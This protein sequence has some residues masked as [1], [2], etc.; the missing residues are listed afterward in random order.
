MAAR[1]GGIRDAKP[2]LDV[3]RSVVVTQEHSEVALSQ[4]LEDAWR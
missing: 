4:P 1:A 3:L 2:S